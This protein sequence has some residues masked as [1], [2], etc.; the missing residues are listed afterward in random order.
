MLYVHGGGE[1]QNK[2]YIGHVTGL[3]LAAKA[4]MGFPLSMKQKPGQYD[5]SKWID[6]V[7]EKSDVKRELK[8]IVLNFENYEQ[9]GY[10]LKILEKD[11]IKRDFQSD[12]LE[13]LF[14]KRLDQR[15]YVNQVHKT[16]LKEISLRH[17]R[18]SDL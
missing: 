12:K 15:Y 2:Y 11:T 6:E 10:I 3:K 16:A 7:M 5:P 17:H 13:E 14:L 18:I 1:P 8:R 4:I 9:R